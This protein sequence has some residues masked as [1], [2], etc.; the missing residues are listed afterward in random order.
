VRVPAIIAFLLAAFTGAAH[1]D[2]EE[3]AYDLVVIGGTPGGVACAVRAAR[4]GLR[5]LLVNHTAHLGGM[6]TNGL[7]VWDTLYD[8]RRS[9]IYDELHQGIL[10]FYRDTYGADSPQYQA[11]LP[12]PRTESSP[13]GYFEPH[14]AELIVERLVARE[15]R[16][17]VLR[18]CDPVAVERADRLIHAVTLREFKG[19]QTLHVTASIYADATY[20]GDLMAEAKTPYRVGREARAEFDEPHAGVVF[21]EDV[22]N[23]NA[24]VKYPRDAVEGRLNLRGFRITTGRIFPGGTGEGDHAVQAYNFRICLT[25]DPANRILPERPANYRREDFLG[26]KTAATGGA[27]NGKGSWNEGKLPG[28]NQ[29]YPN[30]DWATREAIAQRHLDY[31]LGWLYFVQNDESLPAELRERNRRFGLPKDEFADHGHVPYE[32]YVREARRLVGRFVFTEHDALP[33][34]GLGRAPIHDDSI[35]ITEWPM[36]SH[37]CTDRHGPKG[38]LDGKVLLTEETRPGQVPYRCLLAADLDNLLVP[39]CLSATHV[40]W[41]AIR[42][43][44]TWMHIGESAG[45]A[46]ALAV[47]RHQT[48][49]QLDS[50]VLLRTL[51]REHVMISFFNDVDLASNEPWIPAVE[52]FGTKGFFVDYNARMSEALKESTAKVWADGL[53]KLRKDEFDPSQLAFAVAAAETS[54]GREITAGQFAT[55]LAPEERPPIDSPATISRG[56]A[57]HRMF[58]KILRNSG[59]SE[60][61]K[62]RPKPDDAK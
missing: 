39:V 55:L 62:G 20:E 43:E 32:L 4:E 53:A 1:S 21:A 23:E 16:I 34:P 51:A 9:P 10:D 46:A 41:G 3:K 38:G 18:N 25:S 27:P 6:L 36:D 15:P 12:G 17:T 52:Y 19:G 37:E 58:S 30:G 40:G 47:K 13:R 26:K 28:Q 59:D 50:D 54:G 33:A 24:L 49:S 35:A 45:F 29:A 44:P 5:V 31:S 57:L 42:L 7:G 2:P 56:V 11:A 48:P 8:G 14:V 61:S 22:G 60:P